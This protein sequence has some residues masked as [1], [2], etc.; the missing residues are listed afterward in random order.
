V[1]TTRQ[2]LGRSTSKRLA[3][4][5]IVPVLFVAAAIA[6]R[7]EPSAV[8]NDKGAEAGARAAMARYASLLNGSP[9]NAD[10]VSS[11]FAPTGELLPNGRDAIKGPAAMRAFLLSFGKVT[12][13]SEAMPVTSSL[14]SGDHAVLWGTYYQKVTLA[15]GKILRPSG[16][17]VIE[18]VRDSMGTWQIQRAMTQP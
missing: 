5:R 16:R 12:V 4:V 10:S 15:D 8:P 14:V 7:V 13:D 6:C 17:Y 3:I 9:P 1:R 18:W 11:M 2:L